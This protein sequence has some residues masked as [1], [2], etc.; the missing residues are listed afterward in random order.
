LVPACRA[1]L[2]AADRRMSSS[3]EVGSEYLMIAQG[4]QAAATWTCYLYFLLTSYITVC[5]KRLCRI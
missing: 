4:Q 3:A 2:L 1:Y 5:E